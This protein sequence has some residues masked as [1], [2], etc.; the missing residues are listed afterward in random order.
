MSF[1]SVNGPEILLSQQI[2]MSIPSIALIHS[3]SPSPRPLVADLQQFMVICADLHVHHL[4]VHS[5]YINGRA[6]KG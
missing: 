6:G 3:P 1:F 5:R 4:T 2:T